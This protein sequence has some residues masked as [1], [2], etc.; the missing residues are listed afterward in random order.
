MKIYFWT[1][2]KKYNSTI[3]PAMSGYQEYECVLK[4]NTG[5]IAPT[6]ELNLGLVA[7]P[8]AYNFAYI[9]D[10][11]RYYWV[12]EWDFVQST[13]IASLSV[14]VLATW[15][16]Y[17][18]DTDMYVFRSSYEYDGSLMDVKYTTT[19]NVTYSETA[20]TGLKPSGVMTD[21]YYIVSVYGGNDGTGVVQNNVR[22]YV[23]D[24][25]N[26]LIF[27]NKI[28][29]TINDNTIWNVIEVGLRNALFDV[30]S[31][32]K[33]C[34]WSPYNLG[35]SQVN[36]TQI[37]IGNILIGGFTAHPMNQ[38]QHGYSYSNVINIAIPKHPQASGRGEYCNLSPYSRYRLYMYPFGVFDIDT[39]SIVNSEWLNVML[40][41]DGITGEGLLRIFAFN[42]DPDGV[43][44][45]IHEIA[46]RTTKYLVDIPVT[47]VSADTFGFMQNQTYEA[48]NQTYAS[49]TAT[50]PLTTIHAIQSVAD[51]VNPTI[52]TN[53]N[54]GSLIELCYNHNVLQS[55]FI[56]IAED[57][58]ASNG[59][60]L[61]KTRKPVNIPGYI[62]GES[63]TFSAPATESE[64]AEVKRFI[65]NGFY[66]E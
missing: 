4:S 14:D 65:E 31:Y 50:V 53:G 28:Y 42:G 17:I 37:N 8:S 46:V 56:E 34:R 30:S 44:T 24:S 33:M 20:I 62:E 39:V 27:M 32:I 64:M 48:I 9:P 40:R 11:G 13:W 12:Q 59:R 66:Y 29:A 23:F 6:I 19:S 10:F 7:N 61:C 18:G 3:R 2:S 57:D 36:I 51:I 22:Y 49:K 5:V 55:T 26:F 15:R 58:N 47:F 38:S 1:F 45:D 21:G 43:V 25:A 52:S 41:I 60:P 35:D 63:N 16:P 54:I